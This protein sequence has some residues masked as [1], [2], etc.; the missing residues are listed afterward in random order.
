MDESTIRKLNEINQ[1]F[2]ETTAEVFDAT[3]Q[4]PWEGW[5]RLSAYCKPGMTVL[6]V[7]CGNGRF[8]AFLAGWLGKD[9]FSYTGV[10]SNAALL[11]RAKVTLDGM[12]ARLIERDVVEQ[13][14]GDAPSEA[15]NE[16]WGQFDLVALF[17][18]LHHIPAEAKR[19]A[20][21]RELAERVAVGG[22]L[23]FTEWR[24]M[25][26]PHLRERVV[27]WDTGMQV[28]EG[29]YLLDWRR[30]ERALRYCHFVNDAEHTR[31]IEA[32]GLKLMNE[33]RADAANLYAILQKPPS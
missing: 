15:R 26:V 31:L 17:G 19:L 10:D 8:G 6:D 20:L 1:R 29:D 7:G 16:A 3:R 4:Q 32:A 18:V 33:Y 21:L 2:Y 24:F 14:V 30:G 5:Q 12:D 28:E 23:V 22:V 27:V 11:E 9:A 25:D 13:G